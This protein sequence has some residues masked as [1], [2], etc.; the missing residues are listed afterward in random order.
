MDPHDRQ[1][2]EELVAGLV[3]GN[4][5]VE[6]LQELQQ[7]LA[8]ETITARDFISFLRMEQS[9]RDDGEFLDVAPP[10]RL[11]AKVLAAARADCTRADSR[12]A[13]A[14]HQ[15]F[16]QPL[17]RLALGGCVAIG[18]LALAA[19]NIF[20]RQQLA[21]VDRQRE[22]WE[23]VTVQQPNSGESFE[24]QE[25]SVPSLPIALVATTQHVFN[26]HLEALA[27][28]RGPADFLSNRLEAVWEHFRSAGMLSSPPPLLAMTEAKLIGGSSCRFEA[29]QGIRFSYM[30]E[31]RK[32][33]SVYKLSPLPASD[34]A[35][36]SVT[37]P[38]YVNSGDGTN[39]VLWGD[40]SA[41][42]A[43]VADLP[44]PALKRLA[45]I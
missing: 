40:G 44:L 17:W 43:V 39:M 11:R 7:A 36:A 45:A 35:P 5:E 19:D 15:V 41:L 34:A 30:L 1:R 18:A 31:N 6:E 23:R 8:T 13:F 14:N 21:Q 25:T 37:G 32:P 4:L 38:V 42:Y 28:E 16:Q 26:D 27:R 2:L 33:V 22:L 29:T 20:L 10:D 24:V 9:V 12:R 3:L